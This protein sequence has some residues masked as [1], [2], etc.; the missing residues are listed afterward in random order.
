[1]LTAKRDNLKRLIATFLMGALLVAG[2]G[3]IVG[4]ILALVLTPALPSYAE[5][6]APMEGIETLSPS[7]AKEREITPAMQ[8]EM[9]AINAIFADMEEAYGSNTE[10][11]L[12][13]WAEY[14]QRREAAGYPLEELVYGLPSED[15]VQEAEAVEIAYAHMLKAMGFKPETRARFRHLTVFNVADADNPVWRISIATVDSA[16][17]AELGGYLCTID[18]GTGEVIE[19]LTPADAVG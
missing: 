15:H 16:D 8:A 13:V 17:Y 14:T 6:A 3:F 5:G 18:A 4:G 9:D 2:N 7:L 1:M 19:F 12:E 11:P 10:W